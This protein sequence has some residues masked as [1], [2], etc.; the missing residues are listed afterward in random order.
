MN[1]TDLDKKW[2]CFEPIG[3][4][5]KV[6]YSVVI[7]LCLASEHIGRA[8]NRSDMIANVDL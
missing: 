7:K 5:I 4:C 1:L 2:D 8:S 3:Y 6:I